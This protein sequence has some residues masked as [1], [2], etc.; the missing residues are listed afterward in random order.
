MKRSPLLF[1]LLC[2]GLLSPR[3]QALTTNSA[4]FITYPSFSGGSYTMKPWLGRNV[5]LLTPSS[6][7]FQTNVML[8]ILPALD[9]AYDFYESATAHKPAPWESTTF[10][11]RDTIAVVD[12]TCGAG[13]SQIGATG[14]EILGPYFQILYNGV[15]AQNQYDQVLFY[16]FGRNFWFYTSQ[17]AYQ[18]A[19]TDPVVTGLAVY[20]RFIS[21][22]AAGVA[23]GPFNGS[24]PF[25]SFR[26]TVTNL[27]DSYVRASTLNWSNTFRQSIA[28]PN[29]LGLGGSDLIASLLFRIAR[30]FG[31]PK[32]PLDFWKQA[33]FRPPA[34]STLEATDN[35]VLAA[36][37]AVGGNLTGIFT[38]NWKWP[39]SVAALQEARARWGPPVIYHPRY[40]VQ[41]PGNG[42]LRL[43]WQS[44]INSFY[45]PQ[46]SSDLRTWF[47]V[48]DPVSGNGS[49]L[50]LSA[51]NSF[52][53]QRY[54]RLQIH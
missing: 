23:A 31:G 47:N 7:S 44:Q 33:E 37:A 2:L 35:F 24:T 52:Y 26:A 22:D 29:S 54:F 34:H 21:M 18:G 51:S 1:V 14:M 4:G 36:S 41:N 25:S 46:E 39:V 30:D 42:N 43:S 38:T 15:A 50:F 40:L 17:L 49:L 48:S 6:S 53:P 45:Q 16:E 20:M 11:G 32:F 27:M 5:A 9:K 3:V 12:S 19:D 13:C 28:P 10:A 8:K